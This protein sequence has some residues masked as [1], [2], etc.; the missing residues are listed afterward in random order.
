[1]TYSS[2]LRQCKR[3]RTNLEHKATQ[4]GTGT[5]TAG[6]VDQEALQTGAVV[7]EL[8]DADEDKVDHLCANCEVAS[9]KVVV[10]RVFL[11]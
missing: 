7:R 10:R 3:A 6:V 4:T 5:T 1:M 8:P 2:L 11:D 9:R